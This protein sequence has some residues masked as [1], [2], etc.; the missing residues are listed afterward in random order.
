MIKN[1]G[2]L[3]LLYCYY[4]NKLNLRAIIR[5]S[6]GIA[7]LLIFEYKL[8]ESHLDNV[9][10]LYS[11]YLRL[12]IIFSSIILTNIYWNSFRES[13]LYRLLGY[14]PINNVKALIILNVYIF[15]EI[16]G[17]RL[18][19]FTCTTILCFANRQIQYLREHFDIFI[20]HTTDCIFSTYLHSFA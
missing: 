8:I 12:S 7:I 15:V 4:Y 10:L 3:I 6:L 11:N 20:I 9:N 1:N 16:T 14:M 2:Y 17:R 19:F 18:V 13:E 5:N